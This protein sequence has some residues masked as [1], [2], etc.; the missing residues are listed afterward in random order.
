M[1]YGGSVRWG[2]FIAATHHPVRRLIKATCKL[3]P[4][5]NVNLERMST[6]AG[7]TRDVALHTRRVDFERRTA[8]SDAISVGQRRCSCVYGILPVF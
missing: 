3:E 2:Q 8:A 6:R 4:V 7:P 1:H 5:Y